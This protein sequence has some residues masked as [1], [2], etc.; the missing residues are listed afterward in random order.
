MVRIF[1][2]DILY[3]VFSFF[4]IFKLSLGEFSFNFNKGLYIRFS[5]LQLLRFFVFL[6]LHFLLRKVLNQTMP[7]LLLPL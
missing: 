6:L 1:G 3:A 2:S 4:S 5:F 7:L